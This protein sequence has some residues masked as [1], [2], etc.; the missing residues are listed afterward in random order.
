MN[1]TI[2]I[3]H[4]WG[5]AGDRYNALRKIL[6]DKGFQVFAPD[7]PGFGSEPLVKDPMNIDDYVEFVAT[8]F[9]KERN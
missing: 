3:L 7:M 8:F 6:E 5:L 1:K 2:I 4:G 9:E